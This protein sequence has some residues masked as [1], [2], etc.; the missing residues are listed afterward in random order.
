MLVLSLQMRG[1]VETA[2][3]PLCPGAAGASSTM[4]MPSAVRPSCPTRTRC[5]SPRCL[6]PSRLR[7]CS[8]LRSTLWAPPPLLT[9][10][11]PS[12]PWV[13]PCSGRAPPL[14]PVPAWT[15]LRPRLWAL[16]PLCT[17]PSRWRTW[18]APP[19]PWWRTCPAARWSCPCPWTCPGRQRG[20]GRSLLPPAAAPAGAR[21][22]PLLHRLLLHHQGGALPAAAAAAAGGAPPA[23]LQRGGRGQSVL[24][25]PEP[26]AVPARRGARRVGRGGAGR[27][28]RLRGQ[29]HQEPGREAEEPALPGVRA[30][31]PVRHYRGDAGLRDRVRPVPARSRQRRGGLREQ[32]PRTIPGR[33]TAGTP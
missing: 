25:A 5:S 18:R 8:S 22:A 1:A 33:R 28:R 11:S 17:P 4:A 6:L 2:R 20:G 30:H 12:P 27:P 31:V 13:W 16:C 23:L 9:C 3:P 7:P 15:S 29:H 21:H 10:S 32:H 14:P 19:P 26:G 24:A